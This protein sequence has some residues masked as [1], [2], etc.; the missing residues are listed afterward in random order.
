MATRSTDELD[1]RNMRARHRRPDPAP[2]GGRRAAQI[3]ALAAGAPTWRAGDDLEAFIAA[4][5][6]IPL[7]R[8]RLPVVLARTRWAPAAWATTRRPAWPTRAASC[9]TRRASGSATRSAFPTASGTNPM[10]TIM[11]LAHRTA[12]AIADAGETRPRAPATLTQ[13]DQETAR[14]LPTSRIVRD[15]LYIGGE[16]VEP[17]GAEHDR[18]RQRR[19]PR[20]SWA[21]SR[22]ATAADVDRRSPPPAAAF[23][24]WSQRRRCRARRAA[25]PRSARPR[26]RARR[27]SPRSSRQELGMPIGAVA[28]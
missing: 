2:R 15:Q 3:V 4:V 19:P 25:A 10:I 21:A 16:W 28:R 8:R 23:D 5:Q 7:A 26:G 14:A 22:R 20:R 24:A 6:R 11:A 17:A 27:R 12:E 18:R 13:E 1:V 9:T